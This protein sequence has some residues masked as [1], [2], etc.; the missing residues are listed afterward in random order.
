MREYLTA[1][2]RLVE[3]LM[4]RGVFAGT[5]LL[6]EGS[7][8]CKFFDSFV[9]KA[10]CQTFPAYGK[11]RALEI[12]AR[13]SAAQLQGLLAI[14]DA[15]YWHIEGIQPPSHNVVIT[16]VHDI[17]IMLI[18][19]PAVD[20]LIKEFGS[21]S[22]V[23]RYLKGQNVDRLSTALL[24]NALPLGLVRWISWSEGLGLDFNGLALD[25]YANRETLVL[26]ISRL[27]SRVLQNSSSSRLDQQQIERRLLEQLGQTHRLD[28]ICCGPDV[29]QLLAYGLRHALGSC[30]GQ[31][32][33]SEHIAAMLR[34]GFDSAYLLTTN[35][36]R[37]VKSWEVKNNGYHVFA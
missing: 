9:V 27:I 12:V 15:D 6:L 20:K 35:L 37:E 31:L 28:Q 36:Y 24:A 22:K 29:L 25:R 4:V 26:D 30:S 14:V 19:S 33:R 1:D 8:D 5:L 34:M 7:T 23:D 2:D 11:E 18:T 17:E 10:E 21:P 16:D 13:A 32:A 3:L